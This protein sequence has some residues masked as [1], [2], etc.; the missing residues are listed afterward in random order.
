[1]KSALTHGCVRAS[2]TTGT[3]CRFHKPVSHEVRL[4]HIYLEI[5]IIPSGSFASCN[6]ILLIIPFAKTRIRT[7]LA[8]TK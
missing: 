7:L 2:V 1:M 5:K 6:G 4:I 8:E 3:E